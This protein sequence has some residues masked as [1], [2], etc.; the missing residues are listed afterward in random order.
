[1]SDWR[2]TIYK[3]FENDFIHF[4]LVCTKTNYVIHCLIL[5]VFYLR[6]NLQ[7]EGKQ[8]NLFSH[9]I[10]CFCYASD[11]RNIF[12]SLY[13]PLCARMKKKN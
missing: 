8:S 10:T 6:I 13:A 5:F 1:M 11:T 9:T 12:T 3:S 2:P 4:Y 7:C